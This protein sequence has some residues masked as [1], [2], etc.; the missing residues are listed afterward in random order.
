MVYLFKG[1]SYNLGA[2]TPIY[3]GLRAPMFCTG[4][5]KSI[6]ADLPDEEIQSI[7][8]RTAITQITPHTITTYLDFQ[9]EIEQIRKQGYAIDHEEHDIGYCGI[10]ASIYDVNGRPTASLG[11]SGSVKVLTCGKLVELA[12]EIKQAASEITRLI[13]T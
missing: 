4:T 2:R 11:V 13:S 10:A 9:K 6:L 5:G 3:V 8:E 12:P 7:W 1:E